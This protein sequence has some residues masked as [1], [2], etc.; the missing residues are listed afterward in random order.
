MVVLGHYLGISRLSPLSGS[1]YL[2]VA[3]AKLAILRN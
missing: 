2:P 1:L 3:R